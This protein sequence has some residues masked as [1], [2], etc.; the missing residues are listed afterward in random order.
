MQHKARKKETNTLVNKIETSVEEA[1]A[2][3]CEHGVQCK[4][5]HH[6]NQRALRRAEDGA[7]VANEESDLG[8]NRKRIAAL[9]RHELGN[10]P[11]HGRHVAV[12]G[13]DVRSGEEH[14]DARVEQEDVV[15][16]LHFAAE[17]SA[18]ATRERDELVA[19]ES[20]HNFARKTW[21][22]TCV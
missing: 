22:V 5:Q 7:D 14:E 2:G 9:E 1:L 11:A 18:D 6:S 21:K 16:R 12:V 17:R 15:D 3:E 20:N 13:Q 19:G 10:V 8:W 4:Y